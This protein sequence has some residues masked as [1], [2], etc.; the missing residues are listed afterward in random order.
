MAIYLCFKLVK[1]KISPGANLNYIN[2][3]YFEHTL[4]KFKRKF[5]CFLRK[6]WRCQLTKRA[7]FTVLQKDTVVELIM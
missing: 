1:A 5:G 3:L 7:R 4:K 6:L 2:D